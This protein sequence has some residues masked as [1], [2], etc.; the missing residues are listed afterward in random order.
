MAQRMRS[1]DFAY[2][3]IQHIQTTMAHFTVSKIL[4]TPILWIG[5]KSVKSSLPSIRYKGIQNKAVYKFSVQLCPF[6]FLQKSQR[7]FDQ[8]LLSSLC[9]LLSK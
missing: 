8:Q 1:N 6:L 5:D 4:S 9:F 7:L 3:S 2:I